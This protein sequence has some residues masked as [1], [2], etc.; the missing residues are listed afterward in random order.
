LD[1]E[2]VQMQEVV[3]KILEEE[4]DLVQD[5]LLVE[6]LDMVEVEWVGRIN[7]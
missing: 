7:I 2:E 6:I 4:E 5:Q 1:L 3:E